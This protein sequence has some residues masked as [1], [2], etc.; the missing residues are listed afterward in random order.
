[1]ALP[2]PKKLSNEVGVKR[3]AAWKEQGFGIRLSSGVEVWWCLGGFVV[4][5]RLG[6]KVWDVG[7]TRSGMTQTSVVA[8]VMREQ[9]LRSVMETSR[10]WVQT[11][12]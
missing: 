4:R 1:M 6:S 11:D 3:L 5:W 9:W 2:L 7:C 10:G 12:R 8:L